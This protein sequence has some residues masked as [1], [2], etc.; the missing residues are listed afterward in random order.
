MSLKTK[1]RSKTNRV[2]ATLV[3]AQARAGT[4][5]APTPV[6]HHSQKMKER[7]GNVYENKGPLKTNWVGATLVVA[8]QARGR[9]GAYSPLGRAPL[10]P[11]GR[12][13]QAQGLPLRRW[14][15]TTK[16]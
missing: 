2:G 8:Q 7:S 10:G 15:A 13:G 3:V 11:T 4:R 16:N 6:E 14:N 5:P 9:Q 1:D 12:P